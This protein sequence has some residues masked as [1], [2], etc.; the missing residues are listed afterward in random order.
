MDPEALLTA[1]TEVTSGG[2]P[3]TGRTSF[4]IVVDGELLPHDPVAAL[5][6][7]ASA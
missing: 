3:L 6:A 7:G 1:Q 2:N 5:H 4:Q